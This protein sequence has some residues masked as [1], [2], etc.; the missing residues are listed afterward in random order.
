MPSLHDPYIQGSLENSVFVWEA[1]ELSYFLTS[2]TADLE[3][4]WRNKPAAIVISDPHKLNEESCRILKNMMVV[5]IGLVEEGETPKTTD[6]LATSKKSLETLLAS[7]SANPIAAV[8]CCQVLRETEAFSTSGALLLESVAYGTLHSGSEFKTWL[9]K[10]GRRVRPNETEP[11]ILIS[12][13]KEHVELKLNRPRLKNAYSAAM[14]NS[15]VEALRGLA[16][17][18]DQRLIRITGSGSTFCAG[19]DPA[20]FGTVE[21]PA[22]GHMLRSKGNAAPWLAEL[23]ERITVEISGGAVGAGIELAAF[24]S[25]IEATRDAWF[26]LPEIKMGLI[27]GAGGT[28]SIPK[29][30]GRQRTAWMFLTGER[31]NATTALE[32]GLIDALAIS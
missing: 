5:S 25:R 11:P 4:D 24:A 30:I 26:S 17:S 16:T 7:I 13:K 12:F 2:K 10:R 6:V 8:T 9:G 14:R 22:V 19:G 28:V 29:R 3:F 31:I 20:E 18:G 15:L 27:P 21:D 32:W 23:S 1:E